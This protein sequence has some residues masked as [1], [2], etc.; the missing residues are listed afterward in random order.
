VSERAVDEAIAESF[1]A[2]D[3]PAWNPGLARP[4][5]VGTAGRPPT[6]VPGSR[7][8]AAPVPLPPGVIDVSLPPTRHRTVGAVLGNLGGAVGVVLLA[9]LAVLAVGIPIAAALRG[10]LEVILWA[11]ASLQR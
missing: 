2:S 11:V 3:P 7:G 9:P 8:V 6:G 4:I 1:P 10:L 5:P